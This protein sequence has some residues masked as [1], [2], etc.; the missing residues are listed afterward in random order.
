MQGKAR[1]CIFGR[2]RTFLLELYTVVMGD[3]QRKSGEES[4]VDGEKRSII[5]MEMNGSR[6]HYLLI[7]PLLRGRERGLSG[8]IDQ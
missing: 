2:P 6:A 8:G 5:A 7:Y 3:I 4:L 1:P